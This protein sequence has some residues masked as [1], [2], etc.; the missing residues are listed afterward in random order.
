MNRSAIAI[1]ATLAMIAVL[2]VL[3]STQVAPE[4][5]V[6]VGTLGMLV[7]VLYEYHQQRAPELRRRTLL[8][9]G[10]VYAFLTFAYVLSAVR[11]S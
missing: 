5:W 6:G 8:L 1:I 4:V 9:L 2:T 7:A 11:P 3:T 10:G